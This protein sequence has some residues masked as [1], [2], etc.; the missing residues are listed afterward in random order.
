[1]AMVD[2]LYLGEANV[3][4]ENLDS[5]LAFAEELKLKGLTGRSA[6]QEELKPETKMFTVPLKMEKN[7]PNR[8]TVRQNSETLAYEE[9]DTSL[10]LNSSKISVQLDDL[11][12]QIKSMMTKS[13]INSDSGQGSIS[14][15]NVCG[16]E[17]PTKGMPRHIEA[18][19]I[20]GVSH[21]CDICGKISR[22]RNAL[23]KHRYDHHRD[24]SSFFAGPEIV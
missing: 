18:N 20:T 2:F 7:K 10:A 24:L 22:S 21:P 15:C 23:R 17:G 9:A 19:H 6:P 3:C 11:D 14:T 12:D 4:Q 13:D 16:K 8:T 1:M 5:F